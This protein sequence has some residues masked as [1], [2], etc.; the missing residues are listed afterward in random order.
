M[1]TITDLVNID[2]QAMYK[3][4]D[5]W[6]QI[7]RESYESVN[8]VIDY[9]NI[10]HIVFAGVG[11]SGAIGDLFSAIL[12]KSNIHVSLTKGYLLPN[13]VDSNTLVVTTSV[14]GNTA[15][16]LTVL[17]SAKKTDC[18]IIGFSDGGLMMDYCTKNNLEHRHVQRIHS[19]RV[20]FIKYVYYILGTLNSVIPIKKTDVLESLSELDRVSTKLRS[21]NL[22]ETNPSM[23]LADWIEGIPLI[24]YPWGLQAAAIRFKNSLQ[25]NAK[26]HAMAED[27]IEACH[28]G[29]VSWEK[30][31]NVQPI[32]LRGVDDYIKTKERWNIIKEYFEKHNICY[33]EVYSIEG[34]ILSKLVCL[35]YLLDYTSIYYAVGC[36]IDPSPVKSIDFIKERLSK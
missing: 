20:S 5:I 13:T 7:A 25:E 2:T 27:I 30:P 35:I 9:K 14:S 21:D 24:Y 17:E 8:D 12:S 3:I 36:N 16:T 11:G 26:I 33:K 15:E 29:I 10:D 23:M 19:P 32:L 34:N 6:P 4:Y 18:K 22:T 1:L 28:N 31:S